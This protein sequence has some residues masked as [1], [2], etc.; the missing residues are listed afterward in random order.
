MSTVIRIR[1]SIT[2]HTTNGALTRENATTAWART[3]PIP[4]GCPIDLHI[5]G[6]VTSVQPWALHPI[7]C[8]LVDAPEVVIHANTSEP[9]ALSNAVKSAINAEKRFRGEFIGGAA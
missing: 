6:P 7:G 4:T 5:T 8:Y 9:L 2:I 3:G 1:G